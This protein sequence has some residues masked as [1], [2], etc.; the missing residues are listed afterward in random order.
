MKIAIGQSNPIIGDLEYNYKLLVKNIETAYANDAELIIF[1]ELALIGYPPKDLILKHGLI[2]SQNKYI[3]QLALYTKSNNKKP[4][5]IILGAISK[6]DSFGKK[7]FN[8]LLVI[9]NGLVVKSVHKSLLPSYDVFDETR[10][11]EG[12]KSALENIY[13]IKGIKFGLSICEDIWIEAYPSLYSR[14]PISE[15]IGAGA[16]ILINIAASPYSLGKAERRK[17]LMSNLVTRYQIPLIYV[18]QVG[19]NDQLIFDGNSMV[20]DSEGSCIHEVSPFQEACYVFACQDLCTQKAENHRTFSHI[21]SSISLASSIEEIKNVDMLELKQALLLGLKDYVRKCNFKKVVLG[22]SGG[23]DSA[24]VATLAAEALGPEN[25]IA[26]MMPSKYTSQE[27]LDDAEILAKNLKIN[28]RVI[29][30]KKLHE[31]MQESI[32]N[33]SSLA[34]EN[35]QARLRANILLTISNNESALLLCTSNKSE[36]AVGYSTLY[37]DSCGGIALIGDLLKTTVYEL[38]KFINK[39]AEKEIIPKNILEKNPSAEL[40]PE[41]KDQD[42]LPPYEIL[43]QII[44]LYVQ[45]MKSL[46]EIVELGFDSNLV[47]QILNMIDKNEYKRQQSAPAIKLAGKAFGLGR[48]MPIAQGYRHN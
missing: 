11:F 24:L 14:D 21:S 6:N 35:L 33:I 27:S 34:E 1:P 43:D 5:K 20:F 39:N 19:A 23:I 9:E 29:P 38:S 8:S 15:I 32:P 42:S 22:L 18:N 25:V 30:I 4:I 12:S 44:L 26:V 7:F 45:E 31:D 2:E 28:Y 46:K 40:R 37:G 47:G 36:L 41:Q 16:E 48:R 3:E 17:K 13:E 10:Y